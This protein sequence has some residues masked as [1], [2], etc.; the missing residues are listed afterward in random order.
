[1]FPALFAFF[2]APAVLFADCEAAYS[3]ELKKNN[4]QLMDALSLIHEA[5]KAQL[6]SKVNFENEKFYKQLYPELFLEASASLSDYT[7]S[8]L[9]L[10]PKAFPLLSEIAKLHTENPLSP[11]QHHPMEEIAR[12]IYLQNES[13]YYCS[14]D[15][16][17]N[18]SQIKDTLL[19]PSL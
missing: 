13:N 8:S 9:A 17:M 4:P 6:I 15:K 3:A 14:K 18:F 10:N 19:D 12:H 5:K 11:W 16:L 2:L 7:F 1:M